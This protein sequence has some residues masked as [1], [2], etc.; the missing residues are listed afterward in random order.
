MGRKKYDA[1]L[2]ESLLRQF[3]E[4]HNRIPLSKDMKPEHG[5]LSAITF[6]K[7]V[8]LSVSKYCKIQYPEFAK[9]GWNKE[10]AIKSLESFLREQQ[11]LPMLADMKPEHGLPTYA[12]FKNL[13]GISVSKYCKIHYPELVEQAKSLRRQNRK[14]KW[15]KKMVIEALEKFMREQKKPPAPKDMKTENGLPARKTFE[16][17]VGMSVSCYCKTQYPE[18]KGYRWNKEAAIKALERFRQEKERLPKMNEMISENGLP[19][20]N[21]FKKAVGISV[22]EYC[23][24]QYPEYKGHRWNKEQSI[25]ICSGE[26]TFTHGVPGLRT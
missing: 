19:S 1:Q 14:N 4:K 23:K 15:D 12:N 18:Y 3:V 17:V 2:A 10:K 13:V 6:K 16:R 9:N 26:E 5:L 20:H 24:M 22:G 8:R 7:A 11:R 25:K 21:T